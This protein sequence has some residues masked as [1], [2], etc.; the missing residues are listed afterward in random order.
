MAFF[1]IFKGGFRVADEIA[2]YYVSHKPVKP[3]GVAEIAGIL[4]ELTRYDVELRVMPSLWNLRDVVV[5]SSLG[6]S[7]IRMRNA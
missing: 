4:S 2:G 3:V 7:F 6:F 5:E 1:V